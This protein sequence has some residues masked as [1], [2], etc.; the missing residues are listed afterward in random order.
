M[1]KK[2]TFILLI[3]TIITGLVSFTGLNFYGVV[4]VRVLFLIF[5]DLLVIA[6]LAKL[7]FYPEKK[8]MRTI[9]VRK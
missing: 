2:K 4:G 9:K 8:R 3:L 6:L 1:M 7:F 5:A